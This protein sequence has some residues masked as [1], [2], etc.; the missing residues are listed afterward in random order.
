MKFDDSH[1][2]VEWC[3]MAADV[4]AARGRAR[5]DRLVVDRAAPD[6]LVV[7]MGA[8][9]VPIGGDVPI[10]ETTGYKRLRAWFTHLSE[11]AKTRARRDMEQQIVAVRK[12]LADAKSSG[13]TIDLAELQ[14]IDL[15]ESGNELETA[16]MQAAQLCRGSDAA[17]PGVEDNGIVKCPKCVMRWDAHAIGFKIPLHEPLT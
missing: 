17:F 16:E 11:R 5:P 14:I 7:E 15:D 2:L 8:R 13:D 12:L 6:R 3:K 10:A 9:L 1:L 4:A